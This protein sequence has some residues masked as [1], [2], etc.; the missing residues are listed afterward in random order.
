MLSGP[1]AE[2]VRSSSSETIHKKYVHFVNNPKDFIA[3]MISFIPELTPFH[4]K[5][6]S[7]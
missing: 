5:L 1:F 3:L 7:R 2:K 4:G 6:V